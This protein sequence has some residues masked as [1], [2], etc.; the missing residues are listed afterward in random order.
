[1]KRSHQLRMIVD[2]SDLPLFSGTPMPARIH[3]FAPRAAV[4]QLRLVKDSCPVCHDTGIVTVRRFVGRK[5]RSFTTRCICAKG[6]NT[7]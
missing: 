7:T 2:G 3:P 5:L 1:M 6:Q 4:R